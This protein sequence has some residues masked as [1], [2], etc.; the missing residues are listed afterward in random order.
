MVTYW[1]KAHASTTSKSVDVMIPL[2]IP[3]NWKFP[4]N[5]VVSTP[6]TREKY[7]FAHLKNLMHMLQEIVEKPEW[8]RSSGCAILQGGRSGGGSGL[9]AP[10]QPGTC[11]AQL[12]EARADTLVCWLVA[13]EQLLKTCKHINQSQQQQQQCLPSWALRLGLTFF[14]AAGLTFPQSYVCFYSP[15]SNRTRIFDGADK[16]FGMLLSYL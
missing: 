12:S 3:H 5:F 10:R 14:S 1:L 2:S 7:P 4:Y 13:N 8:K 11:P 16:V 6:Y 9:S 15:L